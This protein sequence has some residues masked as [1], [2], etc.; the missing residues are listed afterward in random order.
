MKV[1]ISKYALTTG[2]YEIEARETHSPNMVVDAKDSLAM[3][4][5]EGKEW[6]KSKEEAIKRA[7]IMRKKKIESLEKQLQKL[8]EMKF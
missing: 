1:W 2:I 7:E 3:Y 4:H 6:H 5:G 8:K